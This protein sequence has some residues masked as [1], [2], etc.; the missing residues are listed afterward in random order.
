MADIKTENTPFQ[1]FCY[2]FR[3]KCR[4]YQAAENVH[5]DEAMQETEGD[6]NG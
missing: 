5:P 6:L 3:R 1:L 4:Q 2:S